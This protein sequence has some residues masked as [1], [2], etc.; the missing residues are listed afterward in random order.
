MKT[1]E[2]GADA[3]GGTRRERV[4]VVGAGNLGGAIAAGLLDAGRVAPGDLVLSRRSVAALSWA[5][6]R[7]CEVHADNLAALGDHGIVMVAVEPVHLDHVLAELAPALQPAHLLVSVI[8]GIGIAG[9]RQRLGRADVRLVRAMPNTAVTLRESMTCL[10][11]DSADPDDVQRV[12][13]LFDALGA[14]AIVE[15][16]QMAGATAL[17][18]S[19]LAFFM[20]AIRAAQQAG[21]QVGFKPAQAQHI[22]AQT[23]R[24][25]ASLLLEGEHP[26][27]A[28]DRV[29]TP[30]GTTITGLNR[31]EAEGFSAAMM[32]GVLAAAARAAGK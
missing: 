16:A 32:A 21:T 7:G 18:A 15:D 23:A 25:A 28:I 10:S 30:S 26:E 19:G 2:A 14:T 4:V 5:R 11:S 8:A 9:L 1:G 17:A 13:S 6:E 24:G 27:A 31:M 29:T 20:R 22:V 12:A 3:A